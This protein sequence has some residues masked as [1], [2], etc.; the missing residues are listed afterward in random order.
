MSSCSSSSG[1]QTPSAGGGWGCG[2]PVAFD[3]ASVNYKRALAAVIAINVLGFVVV[4]VGSWWAG[5]ASLAADTLDLAADAA[6]YALSPWAIGKS[7]Q[8][9][10][11]AAQAR[12][13]RRQVAVQR[14]FVTH[15]RHSST[16]V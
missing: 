8:V 13:E 5:S 14:D 15:S 4:A 1:S 7:V 3:G 9:R 6:T 2:Q 11:G 12:G 10:S 16:S